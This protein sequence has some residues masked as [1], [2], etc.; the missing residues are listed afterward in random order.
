MTSKG[1][2][3]FHDGVGLKVNYGSANKMKLDIIAEPTATWTLKLPKDPPASSSTWSI[4]ADGTVT[5]AAVAGGG[6][7]GTANGGAATAAAALTPAN[8]SL[9]NGDTY[10]ITAAGSTAFGF[11]VDIGDYVVYNGTSFD[12][13][14]LTNVANVAKGTFTSATLT[15]NS[16]AITHTLNNQRPICRIW[17]ENN[18]L[19]EPDDETGTSL[20]VYTVDLTSYN[21][22]TAITGTWYY[23]LVG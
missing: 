18:K 3:D 20:T 23:T 17:N 21:T 1:T 7:K 4:G 5:Y 15:S 22:P 16:L 9:Q 13:Q 12:K 2:S 11:Q 10:R 14:D 6:Y 19:I 8:A